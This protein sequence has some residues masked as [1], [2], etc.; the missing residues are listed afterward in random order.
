M[1]YMEGRR[2]WWCALGILYMTYASADVANCATDTTGTYTTCCWCGADAR[3]PGYF[4]CRNAGVPD[5]GTV[6]YASCG[7]QTTYE[8][9]TN[10]YV[11]DGAPPGGYFLSARHVDYP[12]RPCVWDE[13][14]TSCLVPDDVGVQEATWVLPHGW[15]QAGPVSLSGC[16]IIP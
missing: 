2:G 16:L 11:A 10:A 6:A 13:S 15:P 3:M 8:Q 1:K 7:D 12:Y 9:C 5:D 4:Y 14:T